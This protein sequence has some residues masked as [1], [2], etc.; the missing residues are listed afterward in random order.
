MRAMTRSR[1]RSSTILPARSQLFNRLVSRSCRMLTDGMTKCGTYCVTL[2]RIS[3]YGK[4]ANFD[5]GLG[6]ITLSQQWLAAGLG[7]SI[8]KAI[9]EIE[10]RRVATFPVFAPGRA[11]DLHLLGIDRDNLK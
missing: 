3:S 4:G 1:S 2:S 9:P 5:I 7:E 11:R 6:E 8:G 10:S